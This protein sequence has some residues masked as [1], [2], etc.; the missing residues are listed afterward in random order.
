[1]F[2]QLREAKPGTRA[3]ERYGPGVNHLGFVAP[4]RAFVAEAR[5]AM[6]G[7]GFIVPDLQEFDETLAVFFKDPDGF[8]IELSHAPPGV[9]PVD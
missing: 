8:R 3:Y 4:S 7:S 2:V 5:D 9:D 6:A 1:M